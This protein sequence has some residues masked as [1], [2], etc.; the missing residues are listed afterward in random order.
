MA[1]V[2]SSSN[3]MSEEQRQPVTPPQTVLEQISSPLCFF[4]NDPGL[5]MRAE[6]R[7]V[8]GAEYG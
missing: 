2:T 1:Q 4:K 8:G 6:R 7:T 3:E 5:Q